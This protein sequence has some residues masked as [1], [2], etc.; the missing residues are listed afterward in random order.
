MPTYLQLPAL[1]MPACL[2]PS[3]GDCLWLLQKHIVK[4][5]RVNLEQIFEGMYEPPGGKA[6]HTRPLT[7]VIPGGGVS[8]DTLKYV[9]ALVSDG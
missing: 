3:N 9:T 1:N 4:M 8:L 2:C 7:E 5:Q 6:A